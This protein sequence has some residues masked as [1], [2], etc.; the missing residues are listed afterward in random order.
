MKRFLL[1]VA[2]LSLFAT[3]SCIKDR[4]CICTDQGGEKVVFEQKQ[5]TRLGAKTDCEAR[6]YNRNVFGIH[7]SLSCELR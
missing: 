5:Q 1:P 4:L 6:E 3:S 7:T 2:L